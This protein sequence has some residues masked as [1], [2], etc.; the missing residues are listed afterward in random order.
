MDGVQVPVKLHR[1]AKPGTI[2]SD[3]DGGGFRPIRHRAFHLEAVASEY[4]GETIGY[5]A[6]AAGRTRDLD[7]SDGGLHQTLGIDTGAYSVYDGI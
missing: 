5:G 3:D 6:R 4:L 1:R 7:Q 2:E